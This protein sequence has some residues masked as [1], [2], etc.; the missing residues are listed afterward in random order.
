MCVF[1]SD[2]Y[3]YESNDRDLWIKLLNNVYDEN[4]YLYGV[5][6]Y[7]RSVGVKLVPNKQFNYVIQPIIDPNIVKGWE[8]KQQYDVEAQ[9]LVPYKDVLIRLLKAL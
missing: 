7:L 9:N 6:Y 8:N 4:R 5:L 3:F 1:I 2:P